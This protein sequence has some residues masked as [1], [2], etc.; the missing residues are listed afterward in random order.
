M[1]VRRTAV[2][3]VTAL[4]VL[5]SLGELS[6]EFVGPDSIALTARRMLNSVQAF[7]VVNTYGLFA[8]MTTSRPEIIIEGSNDAVTWLPYTFYFKPGPLDRPPPVV[9]PYQPRLDWQMWFAALS[10]RVSSPWFVSFA[11]CLL[12]GSPPV[13]RL[14][15][16]DP[17][18]G[19][20][21]KYVHA[22]LYD[23]QFTTF[24]ELLRTHNWWKRR[25][26]GVFLPAIS[27]DDFERR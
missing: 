18:H 17:F 27:L 6:E 22:L 20:P 14:L 23:Y 2:G 15:E 16:S 7:H 9:A 25:Q 12:Q 10:G 11:K 5:A 26:I 8:V 21:P 13:V 24:D 19:K 3:L 4:V 1:H